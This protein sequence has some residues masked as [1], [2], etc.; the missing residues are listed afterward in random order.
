[1]T[2]ILIDFILGDFVALNG[3]F[4]FLRQFLGRHCI[5]VFCASCRDVGARVRVEGF[6]RVDLL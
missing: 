5:V 2:K 1:M 3:F 6:V 4:N